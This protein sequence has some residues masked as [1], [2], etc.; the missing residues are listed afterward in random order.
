MSTQGIN[1]PADRMILLES[2]NSEDNVL[3]NVD[4]IESVK[5]YDQRPQMYI[6][7]GPQP[8]GRGLKIT[9]R[10]GEKHMVETKMTLLEFEIERA[11]KFT[12]LPTE[13]SDN[14]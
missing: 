8:Y 7:S 6:G 12:P 2:T 4:E 10:S 9:L 3:V 5:R 1:L 13:K 14:E 11:K